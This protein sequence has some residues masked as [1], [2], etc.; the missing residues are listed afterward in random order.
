MI[1]PGLRSILI[2][3]SAVS[4]IVGTRVFVNQAL[5]GSPTPYITIA[6]I[7]TDPMLALDGTYGMRRVEVDVDCW[8]ANYIDAKRM[9]DAVTNHLS[10]FEGTAGD[11]TINAVQWLDESDGPQTPAD[12]KQIG[13]HLVTL[14]FAIHYTP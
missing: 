6:T 1:T 3:D 11:V 14:S 10:D 8:A 5:Q 12:G 2:A 4:A 9:A 7:D 13:K